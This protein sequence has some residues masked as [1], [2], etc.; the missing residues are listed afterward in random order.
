MQLSSSVS[1]PIDP[2]ASLIEAI[3]RAHHILLITHVAPDGDAISSLL[4]LT[5]ALR[6]IGKTIVSSCAN[7]IFD[8]FNILPGTQDIVQS[9]T[10]PFELVIALDCADAGRMGDVWQNLSEPKPL[11]LNIDHHITNTN[12]GSINWIDSQATATAEIVFTL[13]DHLNIPLTPDIATCLLYGIVGDTLGFRTPHTTPHSLECAMRL[14]QAGAALPAIMEHQFNRRSLALIKLWG[15]A[16]NNLQVK[17]RIIYATIS[18][19][20]RDS[21]GMS[22]SG[23]ISLA[24]FLI[25]ANEADRSAVL[26]ETDEGRID[27]S[28][29]AKKGGDVSNAALALGGGGHPLAAGATIDGPMDE[30]VKRVLAALK[31]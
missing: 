4:G 18:K 23:D 3:Q 12:F 22:S 25:S 7:Q 10:E 5:H 2:P 28:L 11:L 8:R 30:A 24:S 27:L 31:T 29:R 16:L 19:A 26:V 17:D 14:M 1:R 20:M 6:A 9:S 21:V 13:I 15:K